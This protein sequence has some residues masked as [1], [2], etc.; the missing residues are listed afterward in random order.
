MYPCDILSNT[1]E[2]VD[3]AN[4]DDASSSV[5]GGSGGR[6]CRWR[7]SRHFLVLIHDQTHCVR[8]VTSRCLPFSTCGRRL[9]LDLG[10]LRPCRRDDAVG[11]GRGRL[12]KP[13]EYSNW[14]REG[15]KGPCRFFRRRLW[16]F[17][18]R[19][20]KSRQKTGR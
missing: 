6:T 20:V 2:G 5:G 15:Q 1:M 17:G 12:P 10:W 18:G 7:H 4:G 3:G 8:L 16:R 9:F 13:R 11:F 14:R 19:T